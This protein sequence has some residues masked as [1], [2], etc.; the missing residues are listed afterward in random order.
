M[1]TQIFSLILP[2]SGVERMFQGFK[3]VLTVIH[4][5]ADA[6][7][8]LKAVTGGLLRLID[9][10]EVRESENLIILSLI[11]VLPDDNSESGR[12]C[13]ARVKDWSCHLNP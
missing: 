11:S 6:F 5:G 13:R 10:V 3:T 7:P 9:I 4:G 12:S 8:P 1:Y 2:M